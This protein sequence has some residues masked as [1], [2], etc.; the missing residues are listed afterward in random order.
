[1]S[2][3]CCYLTGTLIVLAINYCTVYFQSLYIQEENEIF[4]Y[5]I[6]QLL[7]SLEILV[8]SIDP[9]LTQLYPATQFA[10]LH[11]QESLC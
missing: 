5:F 9:H 7:R 8:R 10:Y 2:A 4:K 11:H 6:L 1:M 3:A